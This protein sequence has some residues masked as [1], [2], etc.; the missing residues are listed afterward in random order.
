M[1]EQVERLVDKTW[2]MYENAPRSRRILIGVAGIPGSGKTT[3]AA[4]VTNNLNT[5]YRTQHPGNSPGT[6]HPLAAFIPMDGYHLTRA[7]LDALPDPH[8]A[9]ARR[10]ASFTFDAEAYLS[11]VQALRAPLTPETK[12]VYAPSFDHAVKDPVPDDIGV[13]AGVKVVLFEGNYVAL[14]EGAWAVARGLMDEVWFVEV[15]ME[16]ARE[17]LVKRHVEAGIERD[18]EQ[19][20]RRVRENDLVNGEEIL[21]RRGVVDELVMSVDDGGWRPEVQG[22][23]EEGSEE[24]N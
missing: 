9:H 22:I 13:P 8:N 17:R 6:Q 16:R 24:K 10:G 18:E 5:R 1:D 21:G 3:L 14:D 2:Q 23:R 20:G 12:T 15:E 4:K 19:A 11:L 7:Q